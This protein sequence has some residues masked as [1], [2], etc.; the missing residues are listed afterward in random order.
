MPE[1]LVP[2]FRSFTFFHTACAMLRK[3][4]QANMDFATGSFHSLWTFHVPRAHKSQ[5]GGHLTW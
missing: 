4:D 1:V 2:D 5:I 3:K